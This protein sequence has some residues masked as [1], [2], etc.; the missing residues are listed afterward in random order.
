MKWLDKIIDEKLSKIVNERLRIEDESI[1]F[2]EEVSALKDELTN[3]SRVVKIIQRDIIAYQENAELNHRKMMLRF[4]EKEKIIRDEMESDF[5]VLGKQLNKKLELVGDK[6][7][8][9]VHLLKRIAELEG[10]VED[11]RNVPS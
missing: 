9:T 1:N 2:S 6:K 4:D 10:I 8:M 5:D 7:G 11:K 3:L